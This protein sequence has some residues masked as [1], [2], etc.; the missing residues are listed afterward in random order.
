MISCEP[1]AEAG[2]TRGPRMEE[3]DITGE[4]ITDFREKFKVSPA[5]LAK[6]LGIT[7]PQLLSIESGEIQVSQWQYCQMAMMVLDYFTVSCIRRQKER[8]KAK[9]GDNGSNS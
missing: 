6:G 2:D 3:K 7:I 4:L 5:D 9:E 8:E 1:I